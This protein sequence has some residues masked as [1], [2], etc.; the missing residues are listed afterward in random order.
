[1]LEKLYDSRFELFLSSQVAILFGSLIMPTALFE[2]VLDPILFLINLLAGILLI[3]KRPRLMWF[4]VGVLGLS[5][6]VFIV[7]TLLEK[8]SK[9]LGF[10]RL[11]GYFLFYL[12]VSFEIIR[13]VWYAKCVNKN[14]IFGLVSGFVSLGLIGFFICMSI[15]MSTPNSFQG[16]FPGMPERPDLVAEQLL[17]FSFITLMTIGYG[18][19]I[20]ITG[21]AQKATLLI[22][23]LGNFYLVI[24]T[25][26]VIGK[27]IDQSK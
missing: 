12:V 16:A 7:S 24:V 26:V 21:L 9:E 1:M 15:E 17:Y 19:I 20:P 23:L 4:C 14:V 25:A 3:S 18:D 6:I 22:G 5:A 10:L 2:T 27:F 8:I 13:Q 11:G